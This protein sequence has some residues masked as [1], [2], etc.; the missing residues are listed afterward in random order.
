MEDKKQVLLVIFDGWGYSEDKKYNAIAEANTP[1]F[2]SL[3]EDFPHTLL[4]ASG[5]AVGLPKGEM[6]NSEIGHMAIG[7]G[8]VINSDVV[9][10]FKAIENGDL[11][12]ND[13]FVALF[14]HVKK[15]NSTLHIKGLVSP[16][17]VHSHH[18]HLYAILK[19]AKKNEIKKVVIHA[20]TDGRDTLPQS[21]HE[22]LK[23]LEDLLEELKI[24]VIATVSGRFY[25]MDR[26]NNWDR[27]K[28]VEE[29]IFNGNGKTFSDKKPSE[30]IKELH[31]EGLSDEYLKPMVFLD[32]K[33]NS[34]NI[35]ENDG[36]LFFNFRADRARMLSQKIAEKA[37]T[38]NICFVTMTNYD[39]KIE[40]LVSFPI[41]YIN[42]TLAS[43]V[44]D[45]GLSQAHIAETEKYAHVTYFFNGRNKEPHKKEKHILIDSRKDVDTHDKAPEMRAKNIADKA[46]EEI[47]NETNFIVLNFANPDM[48]GHTANFPQIVKAVEETDKQLKR[49]IEAINNVGG[50]AIISSDH[51]NAEM[52]F[53]EKNNAKHTAHTTNPVPAILTIKEKKLRKGTLADIAPTILELFN[54]KKPKEMSGKSLIEN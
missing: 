39:E 51:G 25:A 28:K 34:N 8:R 1:F 38:D 15:H 33:G 45:A 32:E 49:V 12:K 36:V 53:D 4:E 30:I 29:A 42:T 18:K 2:D 26:D 11:E 13:A 50:I 35:K 3:W 23:E 7:S 41:E 5:E 54:I 52:T 17:G 14:N 19:I 24:G 37:K 20:F 22:Y 6:G 47:E 16:G 21:A 46:I 10:I 9:R 44:A 43:L 31:N 40:S 48:V 27:L